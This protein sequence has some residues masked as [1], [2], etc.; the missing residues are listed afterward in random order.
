MKY[1]IKGGGL[2][3]MVDIELLAGSNKAIAQVFLDDAVGS[4]EMQGTVVPLGAVDNVIEGM[5]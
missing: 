4:F 1:R 5:E 3:I 2:S